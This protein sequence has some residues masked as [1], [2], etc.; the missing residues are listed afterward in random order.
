MKPQLADNWLEDKQRL[1]AWQQPKYDGVRGLFITDQF[2]GRS[3]KPFKNKALTQFFSSPLFRG[4]DGELILPGTDGIEGRQCSLVTGATNSP[5]STMIPDLI[6]FDYLRTDLIEKGATYADRYG[7]LA[8]GVIEGIQGHV[9]PLKVRLMPYT[10]VETLEQV[11][12]LDDDFLER[13]LE[14]SILRN[15]LAPYK[16][17]RPSTKVQELMRIKRFIDFEFEITGFEEA[18]ENTNEA[19]TNELGRSERSTAKAGLVPKGMIG[20]FKGNL[21]QDVVHK[22]VKLFEKGMPIIVGPGQSTHEERV[23]WFN[24]PAE[25]LGQPGKAKTFPHQIKD[26]LRMPIFLSL[27]SAED[28]S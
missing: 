2:T 5:S 23:R 6:V 22:G 24:N 4:L 9:G 28:M 7:E 27:R 13:G 8:G 1:P 20:K 14:G 11:E 12:A 17:G 26:K 21:L 3:L 18:M 19:K 25:I 15:H 10:P 16:E